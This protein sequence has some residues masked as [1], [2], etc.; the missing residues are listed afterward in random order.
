MHNEIDT[1]NKQITLVEES[2]KTKFKVYGHYWDSEEQAIWYKAKIEA[3]PFQV[4]QVLGKDSDMIQG[5]WEEAICY[6]EGM[7][8]STPHPPVTTKVQKLTRLRDELN[9]LI[10]LYGEDIALRH[11]HQGMGHYAEEV[12]ILEPVKL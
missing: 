11:K 2:A 4:K 8:F 7:F 5:L 3:I 9:K 6:D 10:G 12:V 1:S